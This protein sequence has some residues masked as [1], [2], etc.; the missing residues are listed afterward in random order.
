[1]QIVP[2][3]N[4][5]PRL[6]CD[7]FKITI[8]PKQLTKTLVAQ[9]VVYFTRIESIERGLKKAI[10]SRT[11]TK[12]ESIKRKR[13]KKETAPSRNFKFRFTFSFH[14]FK[15][16]QLFEMEKGSPRCPSYRAFWINVAYSSLLRCS[17]VASTLRL[18]FRSYD[19]YV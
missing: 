19:T 7:G 15:F 9:S 5:L 12:G 3:A 16:Y 13:K 17:Y 1:M 18:K 11:K 4:E 6:R 8:S 2:T 10:V 14:F